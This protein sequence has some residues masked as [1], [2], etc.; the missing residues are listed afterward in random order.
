MKYKYHI[1][2]R[3]RVR[4]ISVDG[5]VRTPAYIRG[6]TGI[7]ES[8]AGTFSNP[9]ALAYGENEEPDLPLYRVRF[10]Q[11]KVWSKYDGT[12]YDTI[13]LDLYEHWLEIA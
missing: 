10:E 12:P 13:V 3:I 4:E 1:G 11:I 5:H 8:F 9:E 2:S 6:K 7:V